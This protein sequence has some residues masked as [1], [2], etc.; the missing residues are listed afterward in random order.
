MTIKDI[1]STDSVAVVEVDKSDKLLNPATEIDNSM[2]KS[3]S[4]RSCSEPPLLDEKIEEEGS[5][6]ILNALTEEEKKYLSDENMPLR[7]LRAEK[8]HIK[9][10]IAKCKDTIAWRREF[11]ANTIR[12]CFNEDCDSDELKKR[13]VVKHVISFENQTGK[14][15]VR[16]YTKDGRAALYLKPGLENSKDEEGQMKHLVHNLERAIA[17]TEKNGKEKY[18]IFIDFEGWSLSKAPSMSAS[19]QTLKILQHHY[20]ERLFRC[21]I[22]NPP[23]LFRGFWSVIKPFIDAV[24]KQKIQFCT[25]ITGEAIIAKDFD[26]S[27]VEKCAYGILTPEMPFDSKTFLSAPLHIAFDEK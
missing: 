14:V 10:A 20:P 16:G 22:L 19:R 26:L 4:R 21:Y 9:A 23:F 13:K 15:Y 27:T 25:G 2:K 8:G 7:H 11:D 12:N 6:E 3:K 18:V 5:A 1:P 17:C 24:T